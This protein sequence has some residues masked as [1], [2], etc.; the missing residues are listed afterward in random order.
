MITIEGSHGTSVSRAQ[1]VQKNGFRQ[2]S[3]RGGTGV[4][5]WLGPY[6][7]ELAVGWYNFLASKNE[8]INDENPSCAVIIALIKADESEVLNLED[9]TL[10]NEIAVVVKKQGINPK[11]KRAVAKLYDSFIMRLEQKLQVKFKAVKIRVG[12][13]PLEFIKDYPISIIGAPLCCITRDPG[14]VTINE[15]RLI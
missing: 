3:G 14:C 12:F 1:L 4:Y 5:F 2:G 11:N 6:Y 9:E 7:I 8:F 15:I 10:K 13:P